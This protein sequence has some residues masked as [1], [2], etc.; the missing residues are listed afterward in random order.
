M[1]E[2]SCFSHFQKIKFKSKCFCFERIFIRVKITEVLNDITGK[3]SFM[4][5]SNL[6]LFMKQ[7]FLPQKPLFK[8][9]LFEILFSLKPKLI[10]YLLMLNTLLNLSITFQNIQK[11]SFD[12]FVVK[13][14]RLLILL[15]LAMMIL[16][17]L[18]QFTY[19]LD[20]DYFF[21]LKGFSF[22]CFVGLP[23]KFEDLEELNTICFQQ[24]LIK[25]SL[26]FA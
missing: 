9:T 18:N 22:R 19:I 8:S 3:D 14:K 24:V 11:F 13:P 7:R 25:I 5:Y 17:I 21:Q 16:Q 10:D 20:F 26:V 6:N 2:R 12:R 23:V 15:I 1:F 4:I